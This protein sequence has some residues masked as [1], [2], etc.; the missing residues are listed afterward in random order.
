MNGEKGLND[1]KFGPFVGR[2]WSDGAASMVLKGLRPDES[3]WLR[4]GL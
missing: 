2:F 3:V 4:T 1:F